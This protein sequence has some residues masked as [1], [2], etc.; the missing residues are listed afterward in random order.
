M[1][2]GSLL[3]LSQASNDCFVLG[4]APH[5]VI[6]P[7]QAEI[8]KHISV[9]ITIVLKSP[10]HW[11]ILTVDTLDIG[12]ERS[13]PSCPRPT[14]SLWPHGTK[15]LSNGNAYTGE[16]QRDRDADSVS[17]PGGSQVCSEKKLASFYPHPDSS[18]NVKRSS[19]LRTSKF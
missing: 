7:V 3:L 16:D 19:E 12:V 18:I 5:L 14:H 2:C 4:P 10:S 8:L 13:D 6:N 9:E 15:C 17:F 1:L 11:L